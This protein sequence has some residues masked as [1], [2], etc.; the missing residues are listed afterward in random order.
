MQSI[1]P[2]SWSMLDAY[3]TCP[4]KFHQERVLKLFPYVETEEIKWG[5][6]VHKALELYVGQGVPLPNNMAQ[7]Q[8]IAY[9]LSKAEGDKFCE[10]ET[11]VNA[12]LKPTGYW[13]ADCWNRGKEDLLII[14]GP[15]ALDIDY[16]T[17]KQKPRSRQLEL[18]ACRVMSTFPE[19][20]KVTVGFAWLATGKW[21][22]EV[23]TRQQ[24]QALWEGFY[25][26]VEQMLWSMENNAWP[27]KPSGLCKKSKRP[28]STYGGCPVATCPHS[29]FYRRNK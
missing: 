1:I 7:F 29:E 2:W 3:N 27:M 9:T 6:T 28:G 20:Q 16:K 13:A 23:Y 10:L 12:D 24:L 18:S 11:A 25:E 19:V 21:T 17:G 22:T 5:N 4:Y 14:R 26:G 15:N 8:K